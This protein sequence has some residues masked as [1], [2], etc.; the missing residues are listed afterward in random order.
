MSLA[1]VTGASAGIG[2]EFS[3]QLAAR[4]ITPVLVSRTRE[5]LERL[6]AEIESEHGVSPVVVPMDLSVPGS[7]DALYEECERLGLEIDILINN[8]GVGM[9][10]QSV[11][12]E[13]AKIESMLILNIA[14]LTTL[15]ARFA[16]KMIEKGGGRILNVGSFA[17]DQPT[18]YFASY[19][20][21]KR[22][23]HDFSLALRRELQNSGVDVTCLVPGFVNT[24]FDDRAGIENRRYRALSMRGSLPACKVAEIGLRAMFGGRAR[25]TAG[26]MNKFLVFISALIP[27]RVKAAIIHAGVGWII[28]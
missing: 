20:A 26:I 5:K 6:K 27:P 4:N 2:R 24:G 14:S 17:G 18:P 7:A 25:V 12:Q 23:V 16:S 21:S 1:L 22:Y 3:K 15:S 10:G 13:S 28:R 11:K 19:A 9:F 8:A